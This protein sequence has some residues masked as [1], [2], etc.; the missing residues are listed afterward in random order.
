MRR[1]VKLN[2]RGR[3]G[4]R[5]RCEHGLVRRPAQ[6]VDEARDVV[7]VTEDLGVVVGVAAARRRVRLVDEQRVERLAEALDRLGLRDAPPRGHDRREKAR[8]R[9][10][11]EGVAE[12]HK[13]AAVVDEAE[14]AEAE[15]RLDGLEQPDEEARARVVEDDALP[16]GAARAEPPDGRQRHGRHGEVVRVVHGLGL[17]RREAH[18]DADEAREGAAGRS[19]GHD[20]GRVGI[21][22][23]FRRGGSRRGGGALRWRRQVE[24]LLHRQ[25]KSDGE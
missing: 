25:Q 3:R 19:R 7:E 21:S 2:R 8:R 1:D 17:G 11:P 12:E 16:A 15:R 18:V 5:P 4:A 13:Q 22:G 9:R 20:R 10:P 23:F 14:H 6:Q 24:S